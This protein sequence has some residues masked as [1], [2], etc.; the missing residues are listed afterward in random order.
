MDVWDPAV[1]NPLAKDR[2]VILF[3]NAGVGLSG[4]ESPKTFEGM[5]ANI[6]TFL[7]A[8]KLTTVDLLG[9]SIGAASPSKLHST[10]Q[11]SCDA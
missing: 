8:L 10:V 7:D 6:E 2:P 3:S 9:L 11:V 5:A 1:V 4:G